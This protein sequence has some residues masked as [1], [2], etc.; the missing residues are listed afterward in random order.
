MI[1]IRTFA[2]SPIN[3]EIYVVAK[4]LC[5]SKIRYPHHTGK[6]KHAI[7][8]I[9]R[10]C[11]NADYYVVDDEN[12]YGVKV[13]KARTTKYAKSIDGTLQVDD[14]VEDIQLSWLSHGEYTVGALTSALI[15]KPASVIN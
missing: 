2:T 15:E 5:K 7:A 3:K 4:A 8:Q 9:Q 10:S 12:L 11:F 14:K 6:T 13:T 1:P